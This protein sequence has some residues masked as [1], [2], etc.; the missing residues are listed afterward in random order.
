MA[1]VSGFVINGLDSVFPDYGRNDDND[2]L[3]SEEGPIGHQTSYNST[4][5]FIMI[6]TADPGP[7]TVK[8]PVSGAPDLTG[9]KA[10]S[11][12][13]TSTIS[14]FEEWSTER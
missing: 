11:A 12:V 2:S 3:A 5:Y 7:G 8:W 10:P 14:I 1:D 9:A 4:K 13:Q 6:A